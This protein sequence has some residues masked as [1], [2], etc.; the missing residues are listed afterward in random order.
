MKYNNSGLASPWTGRRALATLVVMT[1]LAVAPAYALPSDNGSA[2]AAPAASNGP[3]ATIAELAL[4]AVRP[5][6]FRHPDGDGTRGE[7]PEVEV[8]VDG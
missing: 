8:P 1:V 2:N 7:R 5:H 3:V 6:K 4:K